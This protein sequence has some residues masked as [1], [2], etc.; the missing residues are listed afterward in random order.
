L[1]AGGAVDFHD[2]HNAEKAS[3]RARPDQV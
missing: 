1:A 2:F 3:V